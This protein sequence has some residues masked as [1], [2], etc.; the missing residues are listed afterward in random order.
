VCFDGTKGLG[1]LQ[2]LVGLMVHPMHACKQLR[3]IGTG[4]AN[5]YVQ[6]MHSSHQTLVGDTLTIEFV[7]NDVLEIICKKQER[8]VR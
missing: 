6:S 2:E 4:T 3:T 7:I 5:C 1:L 8:C